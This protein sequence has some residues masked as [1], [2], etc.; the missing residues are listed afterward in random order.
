MTDSKQDLDL[1][2]SQSR[3]ANEKL[4][5]ILN[6]LY[7]HSTRQRGILEQVLQRLD[8]LER[9]Q[10][11]DR[12]QQSG[13]VDDFM[14]LSMKVDNMDQKLTG[15][16]NDI[17]ERMKVSPGGDLGAQMLEIIDD[18]GRVSETL[19]EIG[20]E[21]ARDVVDN[22]DF[23]HHHVERAVHDVSEN[24]DLSDYI[25]WD[26][27]CPSR[28]DL[29]EFAAYLADESPF[30]YALRSVDE[31]EDR[32]DTLGNQMCSVITKL[33]LMGIQLAP[34]NNRDLYGDKRDDEQ[35]FG[36]TLAHIAKHLTRDDRLAII[37]LADGMVTQNK[38]KLD[39]QDS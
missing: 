6:N 32:L 11:L 25:D 34:E 4:L 3:A 26:S 13:D 2:G 17:D 1:L 20:R 16:V 33:E 27:L 28:F 5:R 18:N 35:K 36:D 14:K 31:H 7:E 21:A 22:F 29:H 24:V 15:R 30:S 12:A 19:G 10:K 9:G 8:I 39:E 23:E 38:E 37:E